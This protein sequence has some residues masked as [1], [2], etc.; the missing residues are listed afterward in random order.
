MAFSFGNLEIIIDMRV[1]YFLFEVNPCNGK[2][3]KSVTSKQT[4][5]INREV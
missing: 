5:V 2:K 1:F 4:L 3:V